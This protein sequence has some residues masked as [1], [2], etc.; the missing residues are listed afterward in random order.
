V[1]KRAIVV[2]AGI[3]GLTA[4][5]RLQQR[6]VEVMVLERGAHVGGKMAAV[7]RDGFILNVGA[8][9]LSGSYSTLLGLAEELGVSDGIVRLAPTIGFYGEREA[10]I[11]LI[12]R[13][14][15]SSTLEDLI[16]TPLLSA[17][18][19]LLL[20]RIAL[21]L[22]AARDKLDYRRPQAHAELDTES[23]SDYCAR[24]LNDELLE[25][26]VSPLITGLYLDDGR[27]ISAA[28]LYVS[29]AKLGGGLLGY[30]GG[31]DFIV[32]A[33]ATR[34]ALQANAEVLL[35]EQ[36]ADGARVVWS[37]DGQTHEERVDGVV[38][39][40]DSPTVLKIH[41]GLDG[42]IRGILAGFEYCNVISV[43][44]A[45]TRR[46]QS[47]ATVV[48][49]PYG[50]VG[51][52]GLVIH[53]HAISLDAA[54]PGAGAVGVMLHHD[55]AT[56]RMDGTDDELLAEIVHDLESL[57]PGIGHDIAF[58]EVNRW[59]PVAPSGRPG[60]QRRVAE[61]N[62]AIDPD[63][64][65]QLAGDFLTIPGLEGSTV[66]GEAAAGRLAAALDAP[67][68]LAETYSRGGHD[69]RG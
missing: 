39:A 42:H 47:E 36:E 43:R 25:R 8:T 68:I 44:F 22:A 4:A 54:P 16:A 11:H 38:L 3:S 33:L 7:R 21:D 63:A 24:R 30:P 17:Q 35:V 31:G 51:G 66:A 46:P 2:G 15:P 29:L 40:V 67:L 53:E 41:P 49:V 57:L 59:Q 32:Q 5:Y 9:I 26:V 20:A 23:V 65:V 52:I 64:R 60:T 37:H 61:L 12:R 18:S 27:G 34:L 13:T 45:L 1:A 55:W 62:D 14:D 58:A 28:G 56:A 19:K 50:A 6:G 69:V 48:V 10:E